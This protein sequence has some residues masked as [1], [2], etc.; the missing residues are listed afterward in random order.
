M[1]YTC[2]CCCKE[3]DGEIIALCGAHEEYCRTLRC[4]VSELKHD[5]ERY[6]EINAEIATKNAQLEN[7]LNLAFKMLNDHGVDNAA[8]MK[9]IKS[10]MGSV[11]E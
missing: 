3:E 2:H 6:V 1:S 11:Q 4:E 5:I 9:R 10:L 8:I 7:R